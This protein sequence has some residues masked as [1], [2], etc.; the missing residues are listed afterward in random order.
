MKDLLEMVADV[1]TIIGIISFL[2]AYW[3]W[4]HD[5]NTF[6]HSVITSCTS[7]FQE[8]IDSLSDPQ[9]P[10]G[11][12]RQYLE[13]CNE[14]VFYFENSY[15]PQPVIIEWLDGMLSIIPFRRPSADF[16]TSQSSDKACPNTPDP[17]ISA[18]FF[19]RAE[20]WSLIEKYPR[21]NF[22]F[23]IQPRDEQR[24]QAACSAGDQPAIKRAMLLALLRNI[25]NYHKVSSFKGLGRMSF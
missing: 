6:H 10:I 17:D 25:R 19:Q 4:K 22:I 7:R 1:V 15:L 9:I 24:I 20:L 23:T 18:P 13:L 14:E 8:L 12:A 2:F 3:S 16:N 5:R 21:L 11:K